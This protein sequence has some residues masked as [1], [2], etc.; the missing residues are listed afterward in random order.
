MNRRR[1]WI[2]ETAT[3]ELVHQQELPHALGNV[4]HYHCNGCAQTVEL[5]SP[6]AYLAFR[7]LALCFV[8]ALPV[9][10]FGDRARAS[11][12]GYILVGIAALAGWL[13][14]MVVRDERQRRRNPA[15]P[16]ATGS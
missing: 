12:R 6:L 5:H 11:D 16:P 4:E 8:L 15:L 2:C 3:L 1:C 14:T 13:I 9:I 10:A 7:A